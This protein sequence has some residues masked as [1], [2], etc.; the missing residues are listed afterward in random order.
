MWHLGGV[1]QLFRIR[2]AK[3][4]LPDPRKPFHRIAAEAFTYHL[5]TYSL[6]YGDLDYIAR[7]FTWA[8][9]EGYDEVMPCPEASKVANSPIIGSQFELFR[10]I[11]EITRLSRHTPLTGS[12]RAKAFQYKYQLDLIQLRLTQDLNFED[13]GDEHETKEG[14]MLYAL[15]TQL[16]LFKVMNPEVDTGNPTI[17]HIS[18]QALLFVEKCRINVAC[19]SYFCWPL[20]ILACAVRTE[21]GKEL[22]EKKMGECRRWTH[23]GQI[24]RTSNIIKA[25]WKH[26]TSDYVDGASTTLKQPRGLDRFLHKNGLADTL[27]VSKRTEPSYEFVES[28]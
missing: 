12:N 25:I 14:A 26:E 16:F 18:S 27:I 6:L 1:A 11:F 15:A 10:M 23:S 24:H 20:I 4:I 17:R 22:I 2:K 3:K 7:Q 8:D 9:L 5:A 21:E 13:E 19:N 28:P